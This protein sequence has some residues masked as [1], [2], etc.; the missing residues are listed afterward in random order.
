[1]KLLT[2]ISFG[3]TLLFFD[4]SSTKV[5]DTKTKKLESKKNMSE[6]MSYENVLDGIEYK[7]KAE[8]KKAGS[9]NGIEYKNDFVELSYELDNTSE[10]DFVVFNQGHS[11]STSDVVYVSTNAD[12]IVEISQKAFEEP[13]NKH[14]PDRFVAI[15]PNASWLKSK[16]KVTEKIQLD[17]PFIARTPFDDC[18]PKS[19]LPKDISQVKFCVGVAEADSENVK[20]SDEGFMQG[21]ENIKE[22]KL[23]CS[24][25]VNLK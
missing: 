8:A 11:G 10:K 21:F 12:G 9:Y 23:L 19:E 5:A 24:D 22:Q 20:I 7:F 18:E 3:L 15:M 25:P 6:L 2:L 17:M 1:M 14:C 16:Q 4:C 13:K